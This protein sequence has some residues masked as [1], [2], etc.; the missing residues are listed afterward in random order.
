MGEEEKK[1]KPEVA[2][3]PKCESDLHHVEKVGQ[4]YCFSC[5]TYYGQEELEKAR[6][7]I[8]QAKASQEN[9]P[10][11]ATPEKKGKPKGIPCPSCGD[12]T[13]PVKDEDHFY[14]YACQEYYTRDGKIVADDADSS[15]TIVE[16][17]KA[18]A[19][20]EKAEKTEETS[21]KEEKTDLGAEENM[22]LDLIESGK[23]KEEKRAC[24]NC[25][26]PLTY[27]KKYDRYYCYSCRKYETKSDAAATKEKEEEEEVKCSYCGGDAE[28]IQKYD[29]Y[30][31]RSCK[32]YLPSEKDAKEGVKEAKEAKEAKEEGGETQPL[33]S[34][35]GKPTT[36]I[37]KY[38]RFYCY[39]CKKYVPKEGAAESKEKGAAP[40]RAKSAK[41]PGP[42]CESCGQPT[43]WIASYERYYCFHCQ[44]YAPKTEE[45]KEKEEAKADI[46][47]KS[48]PLCTTC[49][50]PTTWIAKYERYY[51]YPC[52][53]YSP[54]Q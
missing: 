11:Q 28:Y 21:A 1:S 7:R 16:E 18:V 30:Y 42:N 36:Y 25:G 43:S 6:A 50:K 15:V 31:C 54:K 27:V 22:I 52:K 5:E 17:K 48:A 4:H 23:K 53:K 9:A 20:E 32:R 8:D 2:K 19:V 35:C 10:A 24:Q 29:R 41:G 44:K 38:D 26:Q 45:G 51:C 13:A 12:M 37:S 47:K 49:G 14:C 40:K 46:P 39:P 33:C 3:C 34:N